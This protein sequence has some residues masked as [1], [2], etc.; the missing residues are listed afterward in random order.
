MPS[1]S[2]R[3]RAI[4]KDKGEGRIQGKKQR[5]KSWKKQIER[6]DSRRQ[7]TLVP[8]GFV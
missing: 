6:N 5:N 7:R 3:E 2:V 8:C 1:I 4:F